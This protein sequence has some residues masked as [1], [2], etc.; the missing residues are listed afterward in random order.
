[1]DGVVL[2]NGG[3]LS[4]RLIQTKQVTLVSLGLTKMTNWVAFFTFSIA[5]EHFFD[6][7]FSFA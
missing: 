4:V 1:M 5:L 6:L 3:L 2:W 7:M